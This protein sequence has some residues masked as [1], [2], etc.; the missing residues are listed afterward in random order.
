MRWTSPTTA[1]RRRRRRPAGESSSLTPPGTAA[2]DY[3]PSETAREHLRDRLRREAELQQRH[4]RVEVFAV[5]RDASA[6]EDKDAHAAE[7]DL[8]PRAAGYGVGDD[9]GER[10]LRG[11]RRR[12][13][14]H[15]V[16]P[17]DVVAALAE[18]ALEHLTQ[19]VVAR[20]LAVEVVRVAGALGE[21]REQR[22]HVT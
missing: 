11:R 15:G 2:R 4:A 9:V 20:V 16:H 12:R 14:D 3:S 10:P 1:R 19:A 17:P 13:L 22:I 18:H 8:A 5:A 6:L 21:A 7:A